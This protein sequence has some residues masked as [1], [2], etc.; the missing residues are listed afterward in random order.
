MQGQPRPWWHKWLAGSDRNE[1]V[2]GFIIF[3]IFYEEGIVKVSYLFQEGK[4][5]DDL[6]FKDILY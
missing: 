4:N 6:S 3:L 1:R 2:K 5:T